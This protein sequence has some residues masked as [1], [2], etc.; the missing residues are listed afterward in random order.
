MGMVTMEEQVEEWLPK[1]EAAKSNGES[2]DDWP[3]ADMSIL[4]ERSEPP[5]WLSDP[6][7]TFWSGFILAQ[8]DQT[9]APP[10]Y[11]ASVLLVVAGAIIGN[12]RWVS[13]WGK[14]LQ[15]PVL[16]VINIGDPSSGKTPAE[17]TIIE[18][19]KAIEMDMAKNHSDH[20]RRHEA[21]KLEAKLEREKWEDQVKLAVE[22]GIEPPDQPR[23]A[24]EPDKPALPRVIVNDTTPE[25]LGELHAG[26]PK[27]LLY[28]R[29][30]LAAWLEG[31][32]RY[33]SGGEANLWLEGF[34]GGPHTVDR[35][36]QKHGPINIRYLSLSVVGG[37][38]P[39][40]LSNLLLSGTDDGQAAR[41]LFAW[42]NPVRRRRPS[43]SVDIG[44]ARQAFGRLV[45][46]HM[47]QDEHGNPV[48]RVV[49]LS[50]GAASLFESWWQ[51]EGTV[52]ETHAGGMFKSHLGKLPGILLR[53]SLV[54]EYLG[55]SASD[56][57]EPAQ[58]S[59]AALAA[60]AHLIEDYYRPMAVRA[61][62]EAALPSEER[63]AATIGRRILGEGLK[64]INASEIRRKW[65]LHGLR[66]HDEVKAAL[67]VLEEAHWIR[68]SGVST[69]GR[70]S[71]AYAVN[72]LLV[73]GNE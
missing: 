46:L 6:F 10:D 12:S 57:P 64:H 13:P 23:K 2:V 66:K 49:K 71:S 30:E 26:N 51:N 55:W 25:A 15:P 36:S 63:N 34:D 72:P 11:I 56:D 37:L 8:A 39:E 33:N 42:P 16:R 27:G 43:A 1:P 65:R 58:I 29:P 73:G 68:A 7:G 47:D 19:V 69:G 3:A 45:A 61:F 22:K 4:S 17:T 31:F 62:G 67:S 52:N 24:V 41:F 54:L 9:S 28:Y 21:K 44:A 70:P 60:A 59:E 50:L 14:W 53:L 38:Q 20:L 18:L 40:R 32:D 35:K 48:R 5:K